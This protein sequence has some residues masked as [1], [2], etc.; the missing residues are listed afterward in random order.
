MK[1][2]PELE[3]LKAI[4]EKSQTI[5]DFIHWLCN[6]KHI[7][8]RE[9]IQYLREDGQYVDTYAHPKVTTEKLLAE[10]FDI[11]LVKV[12]KEKQEILSNFT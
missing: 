6:K 8:L 1:D 12:E 4:S 10:Y 2:Y 9:T 5:D 7:Y 11:D 3:K